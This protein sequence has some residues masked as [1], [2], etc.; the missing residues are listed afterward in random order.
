MDCKSAPVSNRQGALLGNRL[1][2][3]LSY[4]SI[5]PKRSTVNPCKRVDG[6]RLQVRNLFAPL[7]EAGDKLPPKEWASNKKARPWPGRAC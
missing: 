2:L 3:R 4:P 7:A 1:V 6:V 5:P